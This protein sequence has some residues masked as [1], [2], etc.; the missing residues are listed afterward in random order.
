M[1]AELPGSI[2][3]AAG[4]AARPPRPALDPYSEA[5]LPT[6]QIAELSRDKL[7]RPSR[8]TGRAV[9][10]QGHPRAIFKRAIE[11]GNLVVAEATARE[12]GRLT[13]EEAPSSVLIYSE[14]DPIKFERGGT[15]LARPLR[16]RGEGRL[17]A[18]GA[19]RPLRRW[20]S[21]GLGTANR[22]EVPPGA[23]A[24]LVLRPSLAS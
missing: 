21:F 11:R 6:L 8:P 24:A 23:S 22:R 7:F 1:A 17:A 19:T 3:S 13:L 4:S 18:H 15:A 14:H 10:A 12:I 5:L 2:S 9:T 20:P 16:D